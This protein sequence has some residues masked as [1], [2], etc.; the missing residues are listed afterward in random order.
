MFNCPFI[1]ELGAFKQYCKGFGPLFLPP[2]Q[3]YHLLVKQLYI[4]RGAAADYQDDKGVSQCNV[5][6]AAFCAVYVFLCSYKRGR[7]YVCSAE[8]YSPLLQ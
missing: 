2:L 1:F 4:V 6:E 5:G 7:L 3:A 8:P